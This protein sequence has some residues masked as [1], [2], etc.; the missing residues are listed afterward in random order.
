MYISS[1]HLSINNKRTENCTVKLPFEKFVVLF[2]HFFPLDH[3]HVQQLVLQIDSPHVM[4]ITTHKGFSVSLP[5]LETLYVSALWYVDTIITFLL[6][7]HFSTVTGPKCLAMISPPFQF[8][9]FHFLGDVL[10][11]QF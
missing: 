4:I 2:G 3:V 1:R 11:V 8:L 5:L 6:S 10:P 7:H 9:M